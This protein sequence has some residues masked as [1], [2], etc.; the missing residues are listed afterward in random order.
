MSGV[1][2]CARPLPGDVADALAHFR[3]DGPKGWSFT[4]TTEASGE[5]LVERYDAAEPEFSRRTLVSK[6]GQPP[7]ADDRAGYLR[8][9]SMGSTGFTAP[10]IQDQLDL[11]SALLREERNSRSVWEFRLRTGGA[12]D[13]TAEFMTVAVTF[14]QPTRTI[15]RVEIANREPFSPMFAARIFEARTVMT[16][17]LP[18]SDTPSLLQRATIH[19]RGRVFWLKSIEQDMIV[20]FS[21]YKWAGKK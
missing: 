13:R 11:T 18:T 14:H 5:C 19:V 10:R 3:A 6:N 4:Q 9:R 17:T 1:G 21:A 20:S 2:L 8:E 7:T 12:D 15:E 16:Y